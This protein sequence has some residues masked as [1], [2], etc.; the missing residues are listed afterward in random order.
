MDKSSLTQKDQLENLKLQYGLSLN[1]V[2]VTIP[3]TFNE[4]LEIWGEKCD[5]YEHD[6]ALCRAW[7]QWNTNHNQVTIIIPRSEV[8]KAAKG[9]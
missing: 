4:M 1:F 6:C 3:L 9:E 7:H 2:E 5:S 8:I